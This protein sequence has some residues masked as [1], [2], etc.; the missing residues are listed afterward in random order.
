LCWRHPL[1]ATVNQLAA[2][3]HVVIVADVV[4]TD[5]VDAVPGEVLAEFGMAGADRRQPGGRI[6]GTA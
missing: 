3:T 2:P 5:R 1:E 4:A 6:W